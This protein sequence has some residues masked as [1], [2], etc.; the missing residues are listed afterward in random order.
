[1]FVVRPDVTRPPLQ[2]HQSQPHRQQRKQSGSTDPLADPSLQALPD[3]PGCAS[4]AALR[5]PLPLRLRVVP[6]LSRHKLRPLLAGA[7]MRALNRLLSP[8]LAFFN[9][10][11]ARTFQSPL[12]IHIRAI[13]R[14][15]SP[16]YYVHFPDLLHSKFYYSI[17]GNCVL[18]QMDTFGL[19]VSGSSIAQQVLIANVREIKAALASHTRDTTDERP[20]LYY[21][22]LDIHRCFD[23]I[24]H[25]LLIR[26]LTN[27]LK[28]CSKIE[29]SILLLLVQEL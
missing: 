22:R 6:N 13:L 1:M 4:R 10:L 12:S 23:F 5:L 11:E 19:S 7:G 28:V 25:Q 3:E 29:L 2:L 16:F 27:Q 18:Q 15:Q 14:I 20:P 17:C 26:I 24:A 21:F 8:L 9:S